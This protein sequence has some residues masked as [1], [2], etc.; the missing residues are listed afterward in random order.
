MRPYSRGIG[1][2]FTFIGG[3]VIDRLVVEHAGEFATKLAEAVAEQFAEKLIEPEIE[4]ISHG[5][6]I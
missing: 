6:A 3:P 5:A 2:F 4:R 1:L